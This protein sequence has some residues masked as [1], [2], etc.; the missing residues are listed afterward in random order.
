MRPMVQSNGEVRV[1]TVYF[2]NYVFKIQTSQQSTV[3]LLWRNGGRAERNEKNR[4]RING[5][6]FSEGGN[7]FLFQK[8][9]KRNCIFQT[10]QRLKS[11]GVKYK[12]RRELEKAFEDS[13]LWEEK[14]KKFELSKE[15][16]LLF[17]A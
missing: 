3:L 1:L 17:E 13:K 16:I 9:Q 5:D 8:L 14:E 11:A 12:N 7:L 2:L 6:V 15:V 10:E 4:K